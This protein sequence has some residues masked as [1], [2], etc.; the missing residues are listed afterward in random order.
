MSIRE[1]HLLFI[2]VGISLAVKIDQEVEWQQWKTKYSKSYFDE[3]EESVHKFVWQDN[4]LFVRRHNLENH[5]FTVE[6]NGFAD[7]VCN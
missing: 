3:A 1:L 6:M 4:W 5:T 2:L 7:L